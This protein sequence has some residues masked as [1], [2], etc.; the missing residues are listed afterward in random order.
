MLSRWLES[1]VAHGRLLS[2]I[3][4][5]VMA[6]LV[7]ADIVIEPHYVRFPWDGLGGFAAVLGFLGCVFFIALAKTLGT[8]LVYRPENYYGEQ[9]KHERP[10][11]KQRRD[12]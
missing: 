1:L 4:L 2:L 12:D 6:A 5:L 10:E 8:L 7:V 9:H 3:T 11:A